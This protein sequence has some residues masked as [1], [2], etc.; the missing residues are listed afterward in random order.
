M[1]V[2][3][4]VDDSGSP[5]DGQHFVLA[6]LI[7]H[8]DNW[9]SFST[10]WAAALNEWPHIKSFKMKEAAGLNGQFYRFS[11]EQRDQKLRRLARIINQHVKTMTYSMIDMHAHSMTWSRL[12]KPMNEVYFWPYQNS[13]LA[14]CFTLWDAGLREKFEVIF[15]DQVIFGPRARNWYPA[16]KV[17]CEYREPD[18]ATILPSE[19]IFGRDED[20]LPIQ[21]ADLFAWCL[22]KATNSSGPIDFEWLL[23]EIPN[24]KGTDYSQYYGPARMAE[25]MTETARQLREGEVPGDLIELCQKLS[26]RTSKRR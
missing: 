8:S 3:V 14:S 26:G 5:G 23:G 16:I 1:P 7:S 21:A 19:P 4:Y 9:H 15:D 18:A 25:V 11:K 2:Q 17:I 10:E 13:I 12:P 22:R 24:V 20:F 6:S